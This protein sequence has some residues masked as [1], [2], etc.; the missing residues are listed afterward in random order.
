MATSNNPYTFPVLNQDQPSF[1]Q[2]YMQQPMPNPE[3]IT[4]LTTVMNMALALMAKA[5]KLN[6]STPTNNNQRISSNPHNRQIAQ[7]GMNMGQ[8][9]QIQ[10]V[11][12]NANQN[13][14]GMVILQQLV[15]RTQL[16]IAQKE[17]AGI[18]LQAEEFHL[19]VVAA[20]L[21]EIEEVNAN[22]ILM[23][24]LQ[25]AST[26]EVLLEKH[27]P[28]VVHDS[29][30]TL[31]LAHESHLK[32]K[33]L[34]KEIKSANYTKINHLSG[35]FVSQ[36]AKSHEELY[37][38]NNSKAVT[39]SKPI[40]IP[41]E[42]FSDDTT[43]SVAQKFL[44]GEAAKFFRD[45]KSLAKEADESLVKHKTLELEIERLLRAVEAAKF[46]RDFKSLAKEADESL[47]KHK[48]LEL[49]IE[50][51][52]R[53]VV[54][55]QKDTTSGKSANTK[56]TNQSIMGKPPKVGKIHALS[57]PVT[58]N[59]IPTPQGS[60]VV[61]NNKVIAPGMFRINP[62]KPSREEKH[63]LNKVRAS[64]RTNPITV[65]QPPVITK[66]VVNSNSNGLSSTG[67]D[68]TKT[69]RPQPRRNTKNDRVPSTSKSSRSKNKEVGVE[70]HHRKLLL[71]RNKKHM[72]S[73]CNNIK[74][75]TQN[76]RSKV[77]SAMCKQC[78]NSV[79]C[80]VCL[81][82][83]V[84]GMNS[85]GCS[86]HMTENLK[87][88]INFVW[89]F[90]GTVRFGNDHV[91]VILG[92]NDLQWGNILIARVYFVEGLGHNLFSVGQFCYLDLEVAFRRNACFVRNLEGV[93]LLKG[94]RSKNLYTINLHEMAS[95]SPI[96]L[97]ARPSSTKSW[98]WDQR[99][100]HL[101]F[102][103]INDLSKNDLVSGLP[104]FK[105]HKEHLCPSCEQGKSKRASHPPKPVP[106]SRQRL[107]L[108]HMDLCGPIR[109]ASINGKRVG[110]SH[111]VSSVRTPQQNGVVER[112][113]QTLVEAARTM[114]IFSRAPLFLW[115]EAIVTACFTQNR[116]IIHHI[117]KLGAKGDIGFF[118]GYSAD[119]CAFRVYNRKKKKI[120]ETMNV[121]FDELSAMAFEQCC[122]KLGLQSITSRQI[123]SGLD[124]T[125]APSSITTQQPTE[126]KSKR[127]SHPPK[128]VP[129]SRQ[130]LH[131]LHMDLCGPI[132][133]AS[134]NGKRV[135]ISHEVSSVRTP[136]QNGVVERRNQ[137]LVEAARTIRK[138]NISFLHVFGALCYPKNDREDIGKLGAKGDIG[139]F[140][141]YSADSCAFRVYN[142]K[143]KKII[144]T[145]NVS[146]DELS[147]MAFEQCC[148]KLGLQSIT[149]RQI[150][151]GLDLTY[152][153]SS[154]TTQQPTEGELD[155]LFEAMYDDYIGD[156]APTPTN[157]SFQATNFLNTSL[158]VEELN[159]QQ[160]HAQQQENQ[161]LIQPE[162]VAD[163]VPNA[164]FDANTF[165]NP[166]ATPSTI[167]TRNQLR[168]D[169]DM[170]MYALT[171]NCM[172]PKNV[173]EAMTDPAWIESMQEELLKFKRLNAKPTEKHL[174]E[175]KR[176]FRY[177]WRIVNTG[178]WYTK[179]SGFELTEFSD[180]DYARCK[181]TFKI[182][183]GGAQFLGEELDQSMELQPHSSR[184]KIQDLMLNQ[185]RYIQNE[186]LIYQIL[187]QIS[188]VQ[189]LPQKDMFKIMWLKKDQ[190]K[191]K[192]GSKPDKNG[193]RD[194]DRKC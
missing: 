66:K 104:K 119:S 124:L 172:E 14:N 107:H 116:S 9:R 125:Y 173:K 25:Q 174:K 184:V 74:L 77:I 112:R 90:L 140:I 161:A 13:L 11:G 46:F 1:N 62:F 101:N 153:P 158:D 191:D 189:A 118:I 177:L 68:N 41:N 114:L 2:N 28:P 89:K 22:C 92:F 130:R 106:N 51:L 59:S 117:G 178:L 193:K 186:S 47:V 34:N 103:T 97:M 95:V 109:I 175:V 105:Y 3:D 147:A 63:V 171:V 75:A 155:L 176:I 159:S 162:T 17:E 164:M 53:A 8:D 93:D 87:L 72:S 82:N 43:P 185:Q 91:A 7:P 167:L 131:L 26:S 183:S 10:M 12:G 69:R 136:Q 6:Y 110:I 108:L 141:G 121:S 64:A 139:F 102:D 16:L 31:Q 42:E 187:P 190:E 134:I 142:R 54:F 45:F 44:N 88:L 67:V 168:S 179:D 156:S 96:C 182:T 49:E 181:D 40:S 150:S 137:T 65:L 160:Q 138:P 86:K 55:D 30:E 111:E 15:L 123:S 48:T 152:A 129:N 154:I 23:A 165:V 78:L 84:N 27:D 122:L 126:G 56:F 192:I 180:A 35:V 144:E 58:S 33:Q 57:K 32:M 169:G 37:F 5:F 115:D 76:L 21:D 20:D 98:L 83:H 79:N 19:M 24:N 70:E 100:S 145:M 61:K 135:G 127:A 94:N 133:I 36:M 148:L 18:Q 73:E 166:F 157:S 4:D 60:K 39:V 50:R 132:R 85:R 38:S 146:F 163:N 188:N 113:N 71:F 80:D 29:K 120:I 151:S 99:L 52:L 194:E 81:L 143:K 149:S 128:P 170:C